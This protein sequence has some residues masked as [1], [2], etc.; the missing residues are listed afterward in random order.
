[1]TVRHLITKTFPL[2]QGLQAFEYLDQTSA[3]KVLLEMA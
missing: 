3:L 1:V 2:E